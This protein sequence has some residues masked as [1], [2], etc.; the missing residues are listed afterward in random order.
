MDTVGHEESS[1]SV[2]SSPSASSRWTTRRW[3][4]VGTAAALAVLI[5]LS[6]CGAWIFAHSTAI[7]GRLVDRSTPAL[8]ASAQ[9]ES[10]LVNQET[11]IRGYGMTGRD[12]FLAPY[13]DGLTRQK[14]TTQQ[15]EKLVSEGTTAAKDLAEVRKRA[16]FWQSTIARPI[17]A[18]SEPVPFA[19]AHAED[20]KR[21]FDFVREAVATQQL[22]LQAERDLARADL[23]HVRALRNWTFSA[24][25]LVILALTGLV[26]AGLRR[27]VTEPVDRLSS[28]VRRVADGDFAHPVTGTGPADLRRLAADVESMRRRLADELAFSDSA[29]TSLSEQAAE[30]RRSNS[31]LEQFAYVAS[32]DLQE[33]LRKVASFCQLLERRY[34][35]RLD[36]RARQYIAFAVDGANRMQ[37]LINDLLAFSRVG[38]LLADHSPLGLQ[39]I[40]DR[41]VDS[42]SMAVEESGAVITHDPLPTVHGDRTQLGMLLQNLLGNAVKFRAPERAPSIHLGARHV[43]G[44]WEFS[45]S[46]NG[47]GIDEEYIERV[48]VIFQRLHTREQYTGNGIGLALCKK[49]VEYHG[50]AIAIDPG[51][52]PGTRVTFTLPDHASGDAAVPAQAAAQDRAVTAA[53]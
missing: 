9:L 24:M 25:A 48:F 22:H 23:Q 5:V 21:A 44:A 2:D 26:F 41:S 52:R 14:K 45:V 35:D 4:G 40:F 13:R 11:G 8:I 6:G 39:E 15:L 17:A 7:N 32:H 18:S 16:A 50:G 27:G 53:P 28:D 49:I 30:L 47:I 34:G 37:G 31:E 20:G 19:T 42:L 46:D 12:E 1:R 43:D 10:A 36:D 51:H 33:P 29:R 3:L 38:R